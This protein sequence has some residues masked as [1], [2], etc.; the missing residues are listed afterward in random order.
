[1]V[2]AAPS[3]QAETMT[4]SPSPSAQPAI[5]PG[6]PGGRPALRR[7]VRDKKIAGVSGGLGRWLGIDPVLIRVAFVVITLF[8]GAGIAAYAA[9]WM[10]L[11]SDT[12]EVSP[13]EALL[14]RGRSGTSGFVTV[15]LG[16][17]A[18]GSVGSAV[19]IGLPLL[20]IALIALAV[21]W[22]FGGK[23]APCSRKSEPSHSA[24][25]RPWVSKHTFGSWG[26]PREWNA[27]PPNSP[28][29]TPAFWDEPAGGTPAAPVDLT[30]P[31]TAR[32]E[33]SSARTT[34]PAW[35]PLGAAPFAWDLPEPAPAES[36]GPTRKNG[37][38][39]TRMFGV[40]AGLI[41]LAL[42]GGMW[43]FHWPLHWAAI[44]AAAAGILLLGTV[45]GFV[46]GRRTQ[47]VAPAIALLIA[48][49]FASITGLVGV[50]TMGSRVVR[51]VTIEQAQQAFELQAGDGMV[52]L[53]G[54][55]VPAGQTVTVTA[56]VRVGQLVVRLPESTAVQATCSV[57]MGD[58]VCLDKQADGINERQSASVTGDAEHGTVVVDATVGTG[59]L[60]VRR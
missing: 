28:F 59:Q 12:D 27:P 52:D 35:D 26:S 3:E 49:A 60:I 51:P 30:K 16:L 32:A 15:V 24:T 39:I 58:V 44:T 42:A 19:T 17:V 25:G 4:S 29:D 38:V 50:G 10:L 55:K 53:S 34:P 11:R 20:P 21:F 9:A 6:H 47:L 23:F 2:S 41:V 8:G 46:T 33:D 37:T 48:T 54:L 22:L 14:G 45:I 56:D 40:T 31:G 18:L 1:M 36:A 13:L 5:D 43:L 7:S 57:R